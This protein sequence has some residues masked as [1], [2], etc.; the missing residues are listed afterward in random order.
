M[1]NYSLKNYIFIVKKLL[2]IINTFQEN[3]N[4]IYQQIY[5]LLN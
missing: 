2:K 5:Q 3:E 1:F 4:L